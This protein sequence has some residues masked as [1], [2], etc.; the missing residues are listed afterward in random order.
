MNLQTSALEE[1]LLVPSNTLIENRFS[2]QSETAASAD[3]RAS[4]CNGSCG[5]GLDAC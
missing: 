3:C 5:P 4:G 2:T 1:I